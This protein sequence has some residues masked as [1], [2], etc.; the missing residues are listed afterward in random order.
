MQDD[1]LGEEMEQQPG[2][3]W[4][5][6]ENLREDTIWERKDLPVSIYNSLPLLLSL[7]G[8]EECMLTVIQPPRFAT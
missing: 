5:G 4:E 8:S 6:R 2:T 3:S 7:L 1:A